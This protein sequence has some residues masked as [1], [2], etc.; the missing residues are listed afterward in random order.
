[1]SQIKSKDI[2]PDQPGL[3]YYLDAFKYGMPE[4][5][6]FGFGMARCI[7]KLC[8]LANAKEAELFPRDT[9]RLTP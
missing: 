4:S 2:N 3:K 5:G 6:G 1:M 9:V 8:G 7:Q